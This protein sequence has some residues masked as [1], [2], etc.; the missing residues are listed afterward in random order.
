MYEAWP[1]KKIEADAADYLLVDTEGSMYDVKCEV[2]RRRTQ[3]PYQKKKK[4]KLQ[5]KS[6]LKLEPNKNAMAPNPTLLT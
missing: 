5:Q 1:D 6:I 2:R 4:T 3:D